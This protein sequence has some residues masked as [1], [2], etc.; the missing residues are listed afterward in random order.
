[1]LVGQHRRF[2]GVRPN[3]RRKYPL[4]TILITIMI[5]LERLRKLCDTTIAKRAHVAHP[6]GF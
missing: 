5:I 1:M 3:F 6:N 4:L 2:K